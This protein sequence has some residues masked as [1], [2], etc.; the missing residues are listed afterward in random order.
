[1]D[2]S[3][4]LGLDLDLD[5]ELKYKL[6][7]LKDQ[8]PYLDNKLPSQLPNV[9]KEAFKYWWQEKGQAWAKQLRALIIEHRNI[10][11]DWQ[12]S[13]EQKELLKQYYNANKLLVDCLNSEC[14]VSREV[15]QH[16][17]DTLLLPVKTSP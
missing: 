8:L 13:N 5:L 1:M 11:H 6:Q 10:G 16:I 9:D 17:E 4:I 3:R 7:Q 12:F 14:Y 2:I 15:R